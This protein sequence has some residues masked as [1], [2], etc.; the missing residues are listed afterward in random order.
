MKRNS[1]IFFFLNHIVQ[2]RSEVYFEFGSINRQGQL[3]QS[4]LR[5]GHWQDR[6]SVGTLGVQSTTENVI[7]KQ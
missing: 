7:D 2:K 5:Q 3:Q 6:I 4:E 1:T